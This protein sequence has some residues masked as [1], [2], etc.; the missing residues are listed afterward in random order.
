MNLCSKISYKSAKLLNNRIYADMHDD[1]YAA[2]EVEIT[3]DNYLGSKK[4]QEGEFI[5]DYYDNIHGKY[6]YAPTYAEVI[7]WLFNRRI[8]IEFKPS[9]TFALVDRVAYYFTVYLK[10]DGGFKKIFDQNMEM[11]SFNLAME[12][13]IEFLINEKYI[14]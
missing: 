7:D 5:D 3:W 6:Y 11:S 14:D 2:E 4:Y 12:T 13:I 9:Y 8:V 1:K 10:D